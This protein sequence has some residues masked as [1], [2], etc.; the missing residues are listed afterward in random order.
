MGLTKFT[1]NMAII[2]ALDDEPNDVG[3]LSAAELKAKFDE[4]GKALQTYLNNTLLPALENLGVETSVQ[5]PANSAGFKFIRLNSDKVLEVSTDGHIWQATGSSGHLILGPDGA[6]LPQRS[7]MQFVNGTV[8]DKNGVTVITGVKGDRGEKG[9]TGPQ[10]VQGTTG[11]QGKPGPVIVPSVDVNG[12]MSF[13]IQDT[14]AAPQSVSVRGP[15]G[16]QGV[17]GQQG[18]QGARG[19]QGI[20]GVAGIQGPPGEQGKQGVAGPQGPQGVAGTQGPVGPQGPAGT[21]GKD[22]TSLYIE[23]TYSTLA[24]LRNALPNGNDK[25]YMTEDTGECHIW[26]EQAKDWVS[27]GKLQG[28]I[29][30]EGPAG[31]QGAQGPAGPQGEQGIPGQT[32]AQGVPGAQ[33]PVG[34]EGPQGPAGVAGKDGK[35]AYQTAAEAGYAGTETAFNAALAAAPGHISNK[36]NPHGVTAKQTGALPMSGGTLTGK[37]VCLDSDPLQPCARNIYAHNSALAVGAEFLTGRI[38]LQYE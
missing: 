28:P 17:Q 24:S 3:G 16:P 27:V 12:V 23:D 37:A 36:N 19:P 15:Q 34:P 35:S 20:Q 6:V 2:A 5:L 13:S 31:P 21:P 22:G 30:P 26:S 32:G 25:M 38:Y 11:P 7:R 33:G 18:A 9:D 1:K 4:G 8:E 10:G 29:G 14:A